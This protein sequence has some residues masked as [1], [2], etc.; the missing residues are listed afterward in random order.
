[1]NLE[2]LVGPVAQIQT[3]PLYLGALS[4]IPAFS[5]ISWPLRGTSLMVWSVLGI[6]GRECQPTLDLHENDGLRIVDTCC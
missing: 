4:G 3:A 5:S 6:P 2:D 1:M